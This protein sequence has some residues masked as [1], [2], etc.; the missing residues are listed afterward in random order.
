MYNF[1]KIKHNIFEIAADG[2]AYKDTKKKEVLKKFISIVKESKILRTQASV[3]HN[4]ETR[5][6]ES[7]YSASEYVKENIAL[8]QKFDI[9]DIVKENNKLV[10]L[11][12]GYQVQDSY[13][14]DSLHENIHSLITTKKNAK[15]LNA[16]VESSKFVKNHILK[17]IPKEIIKED[18]FIPNSMLS[19]YLSDK[20]IKKYDTLSETEVRLVKAVLSVNESEQS[21][22]FETARVEALTA[23]N[24]S[25]KECTDIELKGKLVDVKERLLESKYVK[26][27]FVTD[28]VKIINLQKNLND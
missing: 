13:D 3:Y 26:D 8:L 20:F 15:T 28:I 18:N 24:K 6:D 10:I 19:K 7:D 14:M 1:G 25:I 5:V 17:N 9:A 16:L 23:V 12:E 21:E 27:S 22:I 2:V 4:L 11:L